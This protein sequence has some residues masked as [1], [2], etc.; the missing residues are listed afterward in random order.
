MGSGDTKIMM[1]ELW[2]EKGTDSD[3]AHIES[4]SDCKVSQLSTG[5]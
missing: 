3:V 4:K 1:A 5:R 2:V